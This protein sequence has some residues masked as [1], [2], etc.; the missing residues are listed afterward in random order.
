[1]K[2]SILLLV[3]LIGELFATS[4]M[5]Y[6]INFIGMKMD[7]K[8][9]GQS[10][11]LLDSETSSFSDI[12]GSEFI[13]RYF[14]DESSFIDLDFL[15]V[16]GN[17][18]YTGSYIGSNLGYGSV[19]SSTANTIYDAALAYNKLNTTSFENIQVLGALG[20]GYRFWER[21]LS[22]TQIE[23]YTWYSLRARVGVVYAMNKRFTFSVLGEYQ[24]G[25]NPTMT[26]TGFSSDFELG[27][28]NI[29][30]ISI[31]LRYKISERIDIDCV[32]VFSRQDIQESNRIYDNSGTAYYEPDSTAYNQYLKVGI[33]FKY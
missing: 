29:V 15:G 20:I 3:L 28:A 13:Y 21:Q 18:D 10:G 30:Q 2:K 4:K 22:S 32:Y 16:S 1:M 25:I 14:L 9:Y 24:Y 5:E 6:E 19:V 11:R 26:A 31:P 12:A 17:S 8:E 27:S 23:T 33:I 7:Y